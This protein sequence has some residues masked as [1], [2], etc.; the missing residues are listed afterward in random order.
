MTFAGHLS[1]GMPEQLGVPARDLQDIWE[2][3]DADAQGNC[4][5]GELERA[6]ADPEL[7]VH[8]FT[9]A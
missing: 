3:L 5:R 4:T 6:L 2:T 1:M 9:P 8:V 7:Q